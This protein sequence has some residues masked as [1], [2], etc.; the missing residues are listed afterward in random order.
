MLVHHKAAHLLVG[1]RGWSDS[2]KSTICG[3]ILPRC[4]NSFF[5]CTKLRIYPGKPYLSCLVG[6][7]TSYG[8]VISH[9]LLVNLNESENDTP[10]TEAKNIRDVTPVKKSKWLLIINKINC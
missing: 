10:A 2:F 4:R 8:Y 7:W 6:H 9:I 3:N 5:K 1:G